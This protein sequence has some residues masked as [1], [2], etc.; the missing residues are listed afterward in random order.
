MVSG[1]FFWPLCVSTVFFF[2]MIRRPPRSTRTDTLFPY[3]TLFRSRRLGDLLDEARLADLERNRRQYNRLPVVP[4]FFDDVRRAHHNRAASS[5]IGVA[6]AALAEHHRAGREIGTGDD[7]H[8]FLERD[9]RAAFKLAVDPRK[10]RVAHLDRKS[11]GSGKSVSGR[12]NPG[13]CRTI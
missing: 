5:G 10:R 9:R 1:L 8:Q 7:R 13:G 6:R 12:L 3:T 2:L 4:A 11:G